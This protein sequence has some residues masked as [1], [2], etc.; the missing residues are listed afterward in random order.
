MEH[1]KLL[2]MEVPRVSA[3][4]FSIV[5]RAQSGGFEHEQPCLCQRRLRS[6]AS[7]A[8]RPRQ[9]GFV[10]M[11]QMAAVT[12][13]VNEQATSK[14]FKVCCVVLGDVHARRALRMAAVGRQEMTSL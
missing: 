11:K 6:D 12:A 8:S 7:L 2:N 4:Y 5:H 13:T 3:P 10:R 1:Q 9:S 14:R